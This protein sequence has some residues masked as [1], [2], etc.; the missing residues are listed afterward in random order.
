MP[1]VKLAKAIRDVAIGGTVEVFA[2]DAATASDLEG[3]ERRTGH[4]VVEQSE[5]SGVFRFLVQRTR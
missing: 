4:K 1:I 2:T 5:R 3:F